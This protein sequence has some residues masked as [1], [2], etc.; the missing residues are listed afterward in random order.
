MVQNDKSEVTNGNQ[1][2]AKKGDNT[3]ESGWLSEQISDGFKLSYE[4]VP[5]GETSFHP[6]KGTSDFQTYE[7]FETTAFG[8]VLLVDG[9]LQCSQFDEYVYHESLVH[10]AL[11]A[12]GCPSN[13][14]VLGGGEG[15]TLRE[16]LKNPHVTS[17]TMVDIDKPV[18]EACA[19]LW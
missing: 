13:V 11:V 18:V 9:L 8:R 5:A 4:R 2:K 15:C 6:A 12:H 1:V 10:P 17:A 14:M 7:V 19:E 3:E 16:V